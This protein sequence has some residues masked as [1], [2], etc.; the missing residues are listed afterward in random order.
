VLFT[1]LSD[2][3]ECLSIFLAP[4]PKYAQRLFTIC[5]AFKLVNYTKSRFY[6]D[7][8]RITDEPPR[9]VEEKK[10]LEGKKSEAVFL[11]VCDP[12]MN[13]LCVT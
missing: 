5:E 12:S 13:E 2:K 11:V 9:K 10:R 7:G 1:L 4:L 3:L 8:L 6:N